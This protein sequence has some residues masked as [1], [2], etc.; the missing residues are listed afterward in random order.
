MNSANMK[1]GM[2]LGAG[3]ALV[4]VLVAILAAV[5]LSSLSSIGQ[6]SREMIKEDWVK[7]N[8]AHVIN[9]AMRANARRSME[10]F[11]ARDPAATSAIL[12]N[13]ESNKKSINNNS[14]I[15]MTRRK[16]TRTSRP[17]TTS[18]M[19]RWRKFWHSP[20]LRL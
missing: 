20:A 4:L 7:A 13:I 19:M 9:A 12:Q 8:A 14:K 17:I 5:A 6:S 15:Q 11:F 2:R 18:R 3:F 1:I 10:L 16:R